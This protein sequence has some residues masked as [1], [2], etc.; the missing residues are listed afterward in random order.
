[1]AE[2]SIEQLELEKKLLE[3]T[4]A[5]REEVISLTE[6]EAK[7]LKSLSDLQGDKN[8][9]LE[10]E[11]AIKKV[12]RDL[13]IAES[14]ALKEQIDLELKRS[15]LTEEEQKKLADKVV[16]Y[17]EI[18]DQIKEEINLLDKVKSGLSKSIDFASNLA[19]G[20]ENG[21]NKIQGM[22][23]QISGL[24]GSLSGL[25]NSINDIDGGLGNAGLTLLDFNKTMGLLKERS[26]EVIK[27]NQDVATNTGVVLTTQRALLS[28]GLG[29]F[30]ISNKEL[31]ESFS[32]LYNNMNT[33]SHLN[34]SVQ[35]DL[36]ASAAK[37]K[38]LGVDTNTYA[39]DLQILNTTLGMSATKSNEMMGK[40]AQTAR[41]AGIAPKKMLEEFGP[42]MSSLAVYGQKGV[43]VFIDLEKQS[44]SLGIEVGRLNAIFGDA[45]DTFESA[46]NKA[47][48]LN[49]ILGGDF[50][51]AT[52]MMNAN[53]SE[54]I[55]LLK[56]AMEASGKSFGSM[57]KFEKKAIAAQLG[58]KDMA[59]A[60]NLFGKSSKEMESDMN[61]KINT[62]ESLTKAQLAGADAMRKAQLAQ[63]AAAEEMRKYIEE[64]RKALA[65]ILDF[66]DKN[67]DKVAAFTALIGVAGLVI[68]IIIGFIGVIKTLGGMIFGVINFL[69]S[70]GSGMKVAGEGAKKSMS[71]MAAGLK[72]MSGPQIL[73]A[74]LLISVAIVAIGYAIKI[75]S[76][77]LATLVKAFQGLTGPQAI[78]AV[79]AIVVVMAG[80]VAIISV[81]GAVM[82]AGPG[83]F[84]VLGILALGVAAV[85]LAVALNL[86][87]DSLVILIPYMEPIAKL[88]ID[89]LVVAFQYLVDALKSVAYII[90]DVL[91]VAFKGIVEIGKEVGGVIKGAFSAVVD[92]FKILADVVK[93]AFGTVVTIFDKIIQLAGM[94]NI[95]I[96]LLGIAGGLTAIALA[97]VALGT[98]SALGALGNLIGGAFT[99]ISN[100]FTGG[101]TKSG[102]DGV[103]DS[104]TKLAAAMNALPTD[105]EVRVKGIVQMNQVVNTAGVA[106]YEA[107]S[108]FMVR[109]KEYHDAQRIS[110]DADKDALLAALKVLFGT[111]EEKKEG[112]D[113]GGMK[114][115]LQVDGDEL[116][117][118][119]FGRG[120]GMFKSRR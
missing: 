68:P 71:A 42:A 35:K 93:S 111:G 53:E 54:R 14:K 21:L 38:N 119:L 75:A 56:E 15:D 84:A 63:Q 109:A 18:Q 116:N 74:L 34:L 48:G 89:G 83:L 19:K 62:Q 94:D 80:F 86:A 50:L 117:A 105:S 32:S 110:K 73:I 8:K 108:N 76:E 1:M 27:A 100:A 45:F 2:K 23:G 25:L 95:A 22:V 112:E 85:L 9:N 24:Q 41:E 91:I 90:G 44:K 28:Q 58:I 29:Q 60:E 51:N 69:K 120:A 49:A 114:M 78:A 98:G 17:R 40:L 26:L 118:V 65:P 7:S 102:I 107:A 81:L 16:R 55:V 61:K 57:D 104:V 97:L 103:T 115:I 101:D 6:K 13:S 59:E 39:K 10:R 33:F 87:T 79:A 20:F 70:F 77:G 64:I 43:Q 46:A 88:I 99:G 31:G 52:E 72:K 66:I 67:R 113:Q 11:E 12:N 47:G 82:M 3:E 92:I 4:K 36:V 5:L 96:K 30:G 106:N 37:M